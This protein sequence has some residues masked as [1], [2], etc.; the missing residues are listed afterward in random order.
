MESEVL[1]PPRRKDRLPYP[2]SAEA[3]PLL[4]RATATQRRQIAEP[5]LL[6]KAF[7]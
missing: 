3:L 7:D 6:P 1:S 5:A 4:P 2:D